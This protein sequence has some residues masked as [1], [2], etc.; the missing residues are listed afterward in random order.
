MSKFTG[1][2]TT[3]TS[4]SASEEPHDIVAVVSRH[5]ALASHGDHQLRGACPLCGSPAPAFI[6]RPAHGT[7]HCLSCGEGGDPNRFLAKLPR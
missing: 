5:V 1:V 7:F 6:V 4:D 2:P 3:I